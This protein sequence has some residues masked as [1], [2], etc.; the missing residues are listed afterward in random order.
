MARQF[1]YCRVNFDNHL[2]CALCM[3]AEGVGKSDETISFLDPV[4]GRC[5]QHHSGAL[6][7]Q[8]GRRLPGTEPVMHY[9]VRLSAPAFEGF[10]P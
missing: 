10:R 9:P 8:R 7:G 4:E 5:Y 1:A 2:R 6:P 3:L